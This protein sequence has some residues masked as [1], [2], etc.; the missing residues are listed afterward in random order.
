MTSVVPFPTVPVGGFATSYVGRTGLL[1]KLTELWRRADGGGTGAVL[2]AGEPG[3]G[4][5]RTAAELGRRIHE[6]GATVLYGGCDEDLGAPY[7]PFIEAL[8]WYTAG[9][10]AGPLGRLPGELTRLMPDLARRVPGLPEPV[11]SD[12][13]A[14][15]HR[16]FEAVT[17]WLIDASRDNG[18]VLVLD[19][20]HW[21]SKPTLLLVLHVLQAATEANARLLVVIA[22]RD[23]DIDRA[24]PLS[25]VIGDLRVLPG[26]VRAPVDNLTD[27]EVIEFMEASAGQ[28]MGDA[29][30]L[31]GAALHVE[32]NG[33]P[34]F[35]AEVLRHLVETGA[36]QRGDDDRW[37]VADDLAN[38]SIPE[39][40][41]DVVGRRLSR[42]SANA[43]DIL[44]VAAVQGR[45]VDVDVLVAV[46]D[47]AEPE[48]LDALDE[49]VT[50]RLVEDTG[51]GGFR[52]AHALVRVTLYD[53]L[54][55]TRRRRLHRQT[56]DALEKLR[57]N[58]VVALAYHAAEGGDLER[59]LRYG[60]AAAE[61]SLAARAF[62]DA[63]DR[64]RQVLDMFED[65][66][67]GV[68]EQER[69][70]IAA[71]CGL[72]ESQRDQ[73]NRDFRETLLHASRRAR[74]VN[75]TALLVRSVLA[76]SRGFASIMGALDEERIELIEA[77]LDAIGPEPSAD[78]ARLVATLAAEVMFSGDNERRLELSDQAEAM[79]REVGGGALLA[80]VIARTGYAA[81]IPSRGERLITRGAEGTRLADATGDPALRVH[82]RILYAG[83]LLSAGRIDES[84]AVTDEMVAIADAEGSPSDR[85][86]S[87]MCT[88]PSVLSREG[89]VA[90]AR[91]NDAC[92]QMGQDAGVI[93]ALQWWGATAS[94]AFWL[95]GEGG[96]MADA[97]GVFAYQF[98]GLPVWFSGYT[99]M[100][101]EDG[102]QD[103][104]RAVIE[105]QGLR[106]NT[107]EDGSLPLCGTQQL[108]SV[109]WELADI[110]MARN[111]MPVLEKYADRWS[112][113]FMVPIGPI[114]WGIGALSSV[115]GDHDRAVTLMDDALA[116]LLEAGFVDHAVHCRVHFARILRSRG[117]DGD[118]ARARQLLADGRAHAE[119]VPAPRMVAKIDEL[120]G[121]R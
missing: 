120:L 12:P 16:L 116:R 112:H 108:A 103:Q 50:A 89:A 107:L 7:Q 15:E 73:G 67:P 8:R 92:L 20:L 42:L 23:T 54:L 84:F 18:L 19:D 86:V 75:D 70:R 102:R 53:E 55:A 24:H 62:A 114:V 39:G 91:S 110:E 117:A 76:N 118:E 13:A 6:Q 34:F 81:T 106:Y 40:V 44:T 111:L 101:C 97:A 83:A 98:P 74:D 100:L 105:E 72:G 58:D 31:L 88:L 22:Y 104:A 93:D 77:A 45:D 28:A 26:V 71:L 82:C 59:A 57:R 95:V 29:G 2:L 43:N 4:K 11:A 68:R 64:F 69:V 38:I 56:A 21:A 48:V 121:G 33:N 65:V 119:S 36:L 46:G 27:D 60:L 5:T 37:I 79:A 30:R 17:S 87:H 115:L 61:R 99:W 51:F 85:W 90:F 3:V 80:W 66:E 14:E 47:A 113:Y 49:A 32:T 1:D 35:V 78:R 25:R 41:R 96:D 109:A 9:D 10:T 94:S 63:E 52:F